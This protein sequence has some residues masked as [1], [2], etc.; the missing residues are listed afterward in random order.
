MRVASKV[1]QCWNCSQKISLSYNVSIPFK[2]EFSDGINSQILTRSADG[3]INIQAT[4]IAI[5]PSYP[6]KRH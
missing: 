6:D 2:R 1:I 5:L 3:I 4:K